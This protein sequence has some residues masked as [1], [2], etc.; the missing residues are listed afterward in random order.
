MCY[1]RNE[2]K[3]QP[4][5]TALSFFDKGK[6]IQFISYAVTFVPYW[7]DILHNSE[8]IEGVEH[9]HKILN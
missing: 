9:E 7:R 8:R 4:M 2:E 1:K 5:R 3:E 6:N